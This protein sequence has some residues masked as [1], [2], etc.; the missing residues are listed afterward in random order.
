M[1]L[2]PFTGTIGSSFLYRT[3]N[4]I[5][6]MNDYGFPNATIQPNSRQ[7]TSAVANGLFTVAINVIVPVTSPPPLQGAVVSGFMR[8]RFNDGDAVLHVGFCSTGQSPLTPTVLPCAGKWV[9]V[10][11][12]GGYS[13]TLAYRPLIGS[14]GDIKLV[15]NGLSMYALGMYWPAQLDFSGSYS[16][17]LTQW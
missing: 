9:L 1:R 17:T 4:N 11:K 6:L 3:T 12:E 14:S 16:G 13:S 7:A 2:G 5:L 10:D 15:I 8:I